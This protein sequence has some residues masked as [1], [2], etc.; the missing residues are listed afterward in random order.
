M[1]RSIASSLVGVPLVY[2]FIVVG[3]ALALGLYPE[4]VDALCSLLRDNDEDGG[5]GG[6]TFR[7]A[8][9]VFAVHQFF[10]HG[11]GA[12]QGWFDSKLVGGN[13]KQKGGAAAAPG[14]H[15]QGRKTNDDSS[16]VDPWWAKYKINRGGDSLSYFD[17][18]PNVLLNQF[19][20][21]LP[22]ILLHPYLGLERGLRTD[23]ASLPT[24]GRF[25]L[26]FIG[27]SLC[28]EVVFYFGHLFLHHP[29]VY[30]TWHKKHHTT[31]GSVGIS[32]Q[33]STSLDFFLM[34]VCP[35][36][37]GIYLLDVHLAS[38]LPWLSL[39]SLNSILS[40]GGYAFPGFPVPRDHHLHHTQFHWNFGTG[41]LDWLIGTDFDSGK[42]GYWTGS[43][44]ASAE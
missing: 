5:E 15:R 16:S 37:L 43:R 41:P 11:F 33:Y 23:R 14:N 21:M 4:Q 28:Y 27:L 22:L 3:P 42:P 18:L 29:A 7:A 24:P 17:I 12:I 19:G 39:G 20:I 2:L 13:K 9:A 31:F 26:D 25:L 6:G 38:F 40:H 10:W 32:G 36:F 30:R 1:R 34:T 8:L 44:T 35:G